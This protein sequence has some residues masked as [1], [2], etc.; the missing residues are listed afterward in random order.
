[1]KQFILILNIMFLTLSGNAQTKGL[2]SLG[3]A[4][5][6]KYSSEKQHKTDTANY[7]NIRLQIVPI[8]QD[9]K[10]GLWFYVEQAVAGSEN[11]PYRQRVYHVTEK[12][13]KT[14]ESAV[15]TFAAPLRFANKVSLFEKSLNPDSLKIREGCSVILKQLND[16]GFSGGTEGKGCSSE[17]GGAAYATAEVEIS[18]RELRSWD[19]GYNEKGEQVWGA[20]KSGYIFIKEYH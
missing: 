13:N 4:M 11:K 1:M 19:R 6:G 12:E 3:K 8:W 14:Y 10:D 7:F 9:R 2:Q 16:S 5:A 18:E 15:F 17:R 20:T